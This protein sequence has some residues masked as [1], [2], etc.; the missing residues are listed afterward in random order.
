MNLIDRDKLIEFLRGR[1]K[2]GY[3]QT[4]HPSNWAEAYEDFIHIV[5]NRELVTLIEH[6]RGTLEE[7]EDGRN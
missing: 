5:E 2:A 1:Q 6:I 3:N 7:C 4:A